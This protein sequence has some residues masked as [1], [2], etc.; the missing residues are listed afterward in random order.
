ME[1]KLYDTHL[2]NF[3]SN[4]YIQINKLALCDKM[5]LYLQLERELDEFSSS[6]KCL[7]CLGLTQRGLR[8]TLEGL[9]GKRIYV[10]FKNL[11]KLNQA[12]GSKEA[13]LRIKQTKQN[14]RIN[15]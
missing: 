7:I 1:A 5:G 8:E 14:W 15:I 6:R 3:T 9:N 10:S 4:H 12:E 11:G 2:N 13:S